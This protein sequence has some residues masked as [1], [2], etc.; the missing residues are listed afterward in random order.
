MR[1][2]DQL[3][4][5]ALHGRDLVVF[6]NDWDGDPLSKVHIMRI[7]SRD[8]RVLWV[9]SIGNRAPKANAHDVLRVLNKARSFARSLTRG[10][11]EVEPNLF[12]LAPLAIPLYGS[13]AARA[14]NGGLLRAQVR[15]AMKQLRF[16]RPISW[17]FLPASAPVSGTLGEELV[18][19]HCV[20]EFSAFADT[21]G[22][23][24][25]ELERELLAK[26][27]LVI[28]SAE[29]LRESKARENPHTVLVRH[30]VDFEHFVKA[31]DPGTAV[32]DELACLPHPVVGFF[33][34]IADWVDLEAIEAVAR[35]YPR[36]SVV[37]IGKVAPGV[38]VSRLKALPN[39]R[40]LGRRPYADLPGCCRAFDVALMP[41]RINELTLNANPLKV[42]EYLAAGLPVVSSRIPEV[43]QVGLC[44]IADSAQDFPARVEECLRDGP[45]PSRVRAQRIFHESWQARVEEIRVAVGEAMARR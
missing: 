36:G 6:S 41:F 3:E 15:A 29:R 32:P 4:A 14:A 2:P 26:A 38:D 18:V 45:G 7:L 10:V 28:T 27:D 42:R 1:R 22:R 43:E 30:G 44:R 21:N 37:M 9:N 11:T 13:R 8:N 25:A 31:C 16:E 12:V 17:S 24:I 20:D 40:M 33:G 5:P 39:V 35:A 19:Y 34:L 23:Q